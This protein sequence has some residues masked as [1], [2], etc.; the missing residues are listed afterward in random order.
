MQSTY[1]RRVAEARATERTLVQGDARLCRW[2]FSILA[3]AAWPF[4]T[5]EALAALTGQSVR[6]AAYEVSGEREPSA[7]SLVALLQFAA[8]K[9]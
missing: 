3:K 7:K 1:E 6:A 8:T 9:S 5:A 2:Q 4:K